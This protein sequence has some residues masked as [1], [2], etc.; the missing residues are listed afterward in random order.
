MTTAEFSAELDAR[1]AKFDL[2]CHPFYKAWSEGQLTRDDLREY[3]LDY[4]E[5]VH[6]FPTYLA[7]LAMR[8]DEGHTRRAVLANMGEEMGHE[9]GK[10]SG[11]AHAELWMDFAA[12]MGAG[13]ELTARTV[14]GN[15]QRT[16]GSFV[17]LSA[18]TMTPERMEEELFGSE[19]ASG[20]TRIGALEEAHGGT[21]YIDEIADMPIETQGKVL[22]VLLDQTFQR[23]GGAKK[24]KNTITH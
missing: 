10:P 19:A 16:N 20:S 11:P 2:L 14:H 7:E 3:A 12:G 17:I 5:H 1:I 24:V 13:K 4:Y 9:K 6:A 18:A 15:S 22:R 21:L 23:V 8:L